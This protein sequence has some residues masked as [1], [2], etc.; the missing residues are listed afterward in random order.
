MK[1]YFFYFTLI[2]SFTCAFEQHVLAATF[3]YDFFT[4]YRTNNWV[5]GHHE[6][7]AQ[8]RTLT[9]LCSNKYEGTLSVSKKIYIHSGEYLFLGRCQSPKP[10]KFKKGV[11]HKIYIREAQTEAGGTP[12]EHERN[13]LFHKLNIE[14]QYKYRGELSNPY[15]YEDDGN[16]KSWI[17]VGMCTSR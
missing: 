12:D 14:C 1:K 2:T 15:I 10:V 8:N 3:S 4:H 11:E 5:L 13:F 17:V 9:N 6:E 16:K 7:Y